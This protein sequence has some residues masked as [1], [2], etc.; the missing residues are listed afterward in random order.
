M[1]SCIQKKYQTLNG[2]KLT[3]DINIEVVKCQFVLVKI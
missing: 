1:N 3:P 2:D